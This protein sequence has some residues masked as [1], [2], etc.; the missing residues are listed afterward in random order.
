MY[1]NNPYNYM[2]HQVQFECWTLT[3]S[4]FTEE[5]TFDNDDA[6]ERYAAACSKVVEDGDIKV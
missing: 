2:L 5:E 3:T 6:F 1:L 4:S